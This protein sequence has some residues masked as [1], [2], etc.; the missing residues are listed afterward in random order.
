MTLT[1]GASVVGLF[2]A[3]QTLEWLYG[4]HQPVLRTEF[5]IAAEGRQ[6]GHDA[7]E[8]FGAIE[9]RPSIG[10]ITVGGLKYAYGGDVIDL[11]GLNNTRMAHNGGDRIGIRSHAA[12][13]KRT[14]YELR[15]TIVL[16]LVRYKSELFESSQKVWFVGVAL[17]GLLDDTQFRETYQL[18]EIRRAAGNGGG[19]FVAWYDRAF[20]VGLAQSDGFQIVVRP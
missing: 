19:T 20:L 7:N 9:P 4:D 18:A 2:L 8:M 12:F 14:F 15:P 17:K 6:R 11:M 13:E 10:T 16:P 3:L 1:V 5:E